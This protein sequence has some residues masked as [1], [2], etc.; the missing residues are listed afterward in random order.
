MISLT[1]AAA[2]TI[3]PEHLAW[4]AAPEGLHAFLIF[5]LPK[6]D[7]GGKRIAKPRTVRLST[8]SARELSW[9]ALTVTT[10]IRRR[11]VRPVAGE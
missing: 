5:L 3:W 7:E 1:E 9:L 11:E 2:K 8:M 10:E 4:P 6:R